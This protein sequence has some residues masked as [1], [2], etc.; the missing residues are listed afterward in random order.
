MT[1]RLRHLL[2]AAVLH[3]ML[4]G[5]LAG[6]VQCS[7]KP[8][9]TRIM[10]AVLY[11][12]SREQ[13]SEKKKTDDERREAEKKRELEERKRRAED[14]QKVRD[15]AERLQVE[16]RVRD[17]R[18]KKRKAEELEKKKKVADLERR[19]QED[20]ERL[21]KEQQEK[22]AKVEQDKRNADMKV[23]LQRE[24]EQENLRRQMEQEARSR[25]ESDLNALVSEWGS[26]VAAHIRK[27]WLRPGADN[28]EFSCRVQVQLLPDGAVISAK[29]AR[30]CG[31]DVLNKSVEDAV[32]RSSPMPRPADPSAFVRDLSIEFRPK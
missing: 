16:A 28:A 20:R 11:D 29:I 14:E 30:S 13:V 5:L 27:N 9:P 23:Q 4:F 12:P 25:R 3:L 22:Q 1:F 32:Y 2:V 7:R 10:E 8:Q 17:E 19:K 15:E 24:I 31:S 26:Q 21:K 6:G 18:D